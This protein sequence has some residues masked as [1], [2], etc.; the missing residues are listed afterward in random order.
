MYLVVS[1]AFCRERNGMKPNRRAIHSF[2]LISDLHFFDLGSLTIVD[3][4]DWFSD[5]T[6]IS[7][8]L[9][10]YTELKGLDYAI[11]FSWDFVV[12]YDR[13][14]S[15][16]IATKSGN[17]VRTRMLVECSLNKLCTALSDAELRC[18]AATNYSHRKAWLASIK[19]WKCSAVRSVDIA[20]VKINLNFIGIFWELQYHQSHRQFA[21][22][23]VGK[24]A[25]SNNH[26][27]TLIQTASNSWKFDLSE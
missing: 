13:V 6:K 5:N 14:S 21:Q 2:H 26:L 15:I 8:F 12:V 22:H 17:E 27:H 3:Y 10:N 1:C 18:L 11:N 9:I 20:L 23:L 4:G 19:S 24:M 25:Q 7:N 16:Q